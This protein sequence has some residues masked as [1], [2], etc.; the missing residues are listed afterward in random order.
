MKKLQNTQSLAHTPVDHPGL[1]GGVRAG[2]DL[3]PVVQGAVGGRGGREVHDDR[4]GVQHHPVTA[5]KHQLDAIIIIIIIVLT[6][7][8]Y[9]GIEKIMSCK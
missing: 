6:I 9:I 5:V 3:A 1:E 2:L 4:G 8:I 7:I